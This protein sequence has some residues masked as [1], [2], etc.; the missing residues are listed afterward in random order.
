[1]KTFSAISQTLINYFVDVGENPTSERI[2]EIIQINNWI[3]RESEI[4]EMELTLKKELSGFGVLEK[5]VEGS[6]TDIL[7]N[8]PDSVW[9]DEGAGLK[10]HQNLFN[11]KDEVAVLARRLA[12]LANVRLD[13]SQPFADGLLPSGARLHAL[14]PPIAG[15]CAKISMRFPARDLI[16]ISSWTNNLDAAQKEILDQAI[17]G[18][19][20][21]VITGETGSGKTT[22]LR[23]ILAARP[24]SQRILILEEASE[25]QIQK[26]NIVSLSCRSAN[27]EGH[28]R[29]TLQDLVRQSLRMRPDAIVIGE[30]RGVEISDFLLAVSSGHTGSATTLHASATGIEN[31]IQL[32]GQ[33]AGLGKEFSLDLFRSC[34]DVII[35]CQRTSSGRRI[36]R[37]ETVS[38]C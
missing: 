12:S 6:V 24:D 38:K 37:I 30:V 29:F 26:Q 31:R 23:S 4:M 33:L 17:L 3:L 13:D 8:S 32:L 27:T 7:I 2:R 5:L 15:D 21:F 10:L 34:I 28:G 9:V 19:S 18:T 36:S 25:I 20:S 1:M 14:L 22:L 11:S 16:P 35:H